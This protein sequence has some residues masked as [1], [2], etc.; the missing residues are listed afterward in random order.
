[1]MWRLEN[2]SKTDHSR[3]NQSRESGSLDK[4]LQMGSNMILV[5]VFIIFYFCM[6]FF[7]LRKQNRHK[8]NE[9]RYQL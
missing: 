5:F 1:M 3:E 4:Y 6:F 9:G 2:K 7:P 8:G